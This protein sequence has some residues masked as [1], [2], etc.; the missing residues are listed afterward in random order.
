M[1]L[2]VPSS[3]NEKASSA[4]QSGLFSA[5]TR[6]L[7]SVLG[8]SEIAYKRIELEVLGNFQLPASP[9]NTIGGVPAAISSSSEYPSPSSSVSALLPTPSESVSRDSLESNGNASKLF[10]TPSLSLSS[11]HAS[12]TPSLSVSV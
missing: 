1:F 12:P 10:I 4:T 11:S 9:L 3:P 8:V 6:K 7:K 5:V 2:N